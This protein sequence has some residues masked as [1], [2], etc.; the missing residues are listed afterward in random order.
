MTLV[1]CEDCEDENEVCVF[2]KKAKK[3]RFLCSYFVYPKKYSKTF[4][5]LSLFLLNAARKTHDDA[6]LIRN[7]NTRRR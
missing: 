2:G 3:R 6:H 4:S 5:S 1:C 7:R